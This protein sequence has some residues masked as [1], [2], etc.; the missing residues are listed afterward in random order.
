MA[1]FDYLHSLAYCF[2]L[3]L[4]NQTFASPVI[5]AFKLKRNGEVTQ[6]RMKMT[7]SAYVKDFSGLNKMMK[8]FED[9]IDNE[10]VRRKIMEAQMKYPFAFSSSRMAAA[11][12]FINTEIPSIIYNDSTIASGNGILLQIFDDGTVNG[13]M[14]LRSPYGM[15]NV[16]LTQYLYA[17]KLL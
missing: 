14:D 4:L 6:N 5:E 7:K 12:Q 9:K 15:L 11:L 16:L 13:T 8:S 3:F 17:I 1:C 10:D 2:V